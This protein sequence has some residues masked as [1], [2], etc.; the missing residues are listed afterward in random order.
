MKRYLLFL[1]LFIHHT[2][3]QARENQIEII[4]S[5]STNL[6]Q[7]E[8]VTLSVSNAPSGATFQWVKDGADLSSAVSSSLLVNTAGKY[9]VRVNG[10]ALTEVTVVVNPRPKADFT[11]TPAGGCGK[12]RINFSSTSTNGGTPPTNADLQYQWDFGDGKSS[13][14]QNPAHTFDPGRGTGTTVF[15]VRLIV[16]NS[17]G[18]KDTITRALSIGKSPDPTLLSSSQFQVINGEPYFKICAATGQRFEFLNGSGTSATNTQYIIR[19]GDGTPDFV[20]N[21]F[22]SFITHDYPVGLK[23]LTFIVYSGTCVDSTVYNIFVGNIPAGG[24]TGLGGSTICAGDA[25]RFVISGTANNPPGTIYV[26]NY[27]DGTRNDTFFHPAPD[28]VIHIYPKSSCGTSSSTG[29]TNF[30]N[31]FG[32]Y[33]TITNPCGTASGSIVPI[34]V[35]DK[36]KADFSISRDSICENQ[37]VTFTNTGI[38]GNNVQG[39][40]CTPGKIV[41]R[42]SS[43]TPGASWTVTSGTLGNT[44]GSLNPNFWNPAGTNALTV[45]FNTQGIYSITQITANN[46]LCGADSVTKTICVNPLPTAAFTLDKDNG[47]A[48]LNVTAAGTTNVPFCGNN[49][50][51]WTVSYTPT[52]GCT[53]AAS[54]F[55]YTGGTNQNSQNPQFLFSNPGVY[56]I[57]LQTFAP[58]NSCSSAVVQQQVVVR[59]KPV[60]SLNVPAE[61]CEGASISPTAT[62]TCYTASATYSWLFGGANP[63]SASQLNPGSI[64]YTAPGNYNIQFSATNECG[65]TTL[66]R[67]VVIKPTPQVNL[68]GN[69]VVCAG[70]TVGP[71]NFTT[72]PPGASLSWS[73][74]N[75]AIGLAASGMGNINAFTA[76]NN[77]SNPLIATISVTPT[78]NGCSGPA[79]TMTITVNPRPVVTVNSAA[80]CLGS[81]VQLNAGGADTYSWSPATGLSAVT[82]SSVTASPSTTTVYTVT[83]TNMA[84]G[85]F[86]SATATVTVNPVPSIAATFSNP[87]TCGSATGSITITG[88]TSNISYTVNYLR[89]GL[90]QP[91]LVRTATS[92]GIIVISGLTAATYSDIRVLLNGCASNAVG[93]FSLSDP[94]PPTVT[95]PSS[96]LIVCAGGATGLITFSANPSG[97]TVNWTNNNTSI[98]LAASG[99]SNIASFIASNNTTSPVTAT[100]TVTAT[101]AGCTS[102]AQTFRIVVNPRPQVSVNSPTICSG[103]SATLTVNGAAD[104][105]VWSPAA[106][107]N[108]TSGNTVVANP[109]TT[110]LYTIVASFTATGCSSTISSNVTVRPT[111]AIT[112]TTANPAACGASNGSITIAGLNP[113]TSYTVNYTRNGVAQ[114][115]VTRSSN[116]SG[117]LTLTN[118][119]AGT[120]SDIQ[121]TLNGCVSNTAG[122]F[123]LTDPS[124]PDQPI[125]PSVAPVC[126]GGTITL[127]ISNP[128]SGATYIWTGPNG[129]NQT[130]TATSVTISNASVAASGTY[131]AV[132]RLSNCNSSPGSVDVIVNPRPAVNVNSGFVCIGNSI[133]LTASGA[134]TYVWTPATGL[135]T[136]TGETVIASPTTNTNYTVTGTITATGCSNSAVSTVTVRTTPVISGDFMQ[137]TSC[138]ASN[139]SITIRQLTAGLNYSFTYTRNGIS[140]SGT[141][142]ASG[143]GTIVIANLPAGLYADIRVVLNGCTSNAI[144][145]FQL[146]EPSAPA[147][148]VVTSNSPL[149]SGNTL[150]IAVGNPV[151]G[152]TY[153]WAGPNGFSQTTTLPEVSIPNAQ[154]NRSGSYTVVMTTNNCPS[155]PASVSITVNPTPP[156]PIVSSPV[157]YCQGEPALP[158][159]AIAENGNTLLWYS[160]SSGG[161]GSSTAPTPSTNNTGSNSFFVSQITPEGCEGPRARIDVTVNATPV[162]VN[163]Q[164]TI[165]SGGAISFVPPGTPAGTVF[166]W[167]TP[168]LTAGLSGGAGGSGSSITGVFTN[169]TD[170]PQ[171]ATYNVSTI[172]GNCPGNDFQLIVTVNP[173]PF[174]PDL[175]TEI[176][177]GDI[178][179]ITPG[180]TIPNI[181][182]PAGTTYSWLTPVVT[183]AGAVS[184]ISAQSMGQTSISQQL[185][186]TTN[187]PA[188]VTYTVTPMSTSAGSC[189]GQPFTVVVKVNPRPSIPNQ[190]V[191]ICSG[192][193][194]RVSPQNNPPGSIVPAN[195]MYIWSAP[196]SNPAGAITGGTAQNIPQPF[197]GQTLVNTTVSPATISYTVTPISGDEGNCTGQPFEVVVTVNPQPA[198]SDI[199]TTICSNNFF[200]V[201]PANVPAN[202]T[203]TW[204]MPVSNP[205]GAITGG[206]AQAIPQ[207]AVSQRLISNINVPATLTYTVTPS[208]GSCGNS[209][210]NVVVTVNPAPK[211]PAQQL[212][213]C[214]GQTFDLRF[215][216]NPP[217][218]I[219]PVNTT[220]TWPLPL[221]NPAGIVSGGAIQTT[222]V[223]GIR[224]T[225]FN[226]SDA[227]ATLNYVITPVSGVPGNCPGEPF[228]LLAT[229]H[230]DA[231][232]RFTVLFDTAC[233]PFSIDKQVLINTSPVTATETFEWYANNVLIGTGRDFPGYVLSA[234]GDSVVIKMIARSKFGCKP[235]SVQK[236]FFTKLKPDASFVNANKGGCGPLSVNF[237]NTS[238]F[239][240]SFRYAWNFGNG[241]TSSLYQPGPIVFLPNPNFGDTSYLVTLLAFNE[242]DT[243]RFTTTINVQSGPQARFTPDKTVG[244]SPMTVTFNNTSRGINNTY[245]WNFGDGTVLTASDATPVSHTYFSGVRDTFVVRLIAVN[246]CGSDTAEFNVVITPNTIK[247]D[248]AV[249]GLEQNG[250]APHTVRFINNSSGASV[251][252]WDFGDGNILSTTKNKDT[253]VH[254]FIRLGSYRVKLTASNACSDTTTTEL[255]EVFN[256]PV[257]DFTPNVF[258]A[259][260]GDALKFENQSSGDATSYLWK[261]GDGNTSSLVS[262]THQYRLPGTYTVTL[263]AFKN[264]AP[265]SVCSDSIKRV[266]NIVDSLPI[267]FSVSANLGTCTPFKVRFTNNFLGYASLVWD[268]GDGNKGTGDNIEHTYMR[269]G[270]YF[271][272]LTITTPAGC[273]YTGVKRIEVVSPE[274]SLRVQTGVN[275]L[276][277]AV[278]FEALPVNAD[279]IIW[280][281]GDGTILKTTT[282]VVFHQ[283]R[284]PGTYYPTAQFKSND[285]CIYQVPDINEVKIDRIVSG[286][287]V[288]QQQECGKTIVRFTDTSN[289]FFGKNAVSWK[290]GDGAT[291]TGNVVTHTYTLSKPYLVQQI[292]TG[293]SGCADTLEMPVDVFVR[294]VPDAQ[295]QIPNLVCTNTPVDFRAL[296]QS[297]DPIVVN[298]WRFSNGIT[299]DKQDL[300]LTFATPGNYDVR[301]IAGTRFGCFDTAS[302]SFRVY[303]SPLVRAVPDVTICRGSSVSLS[304]S[305]AAQYTWY[306]DNGLTCV[307]C[308][309]TTA[310]P[311]VTTPYTVKGT[312]TDGCIAYDTVLVRVVQPFKM[313]VEPG[314]SICIGQS[315]QLLA[316]G[317]S[318][319]QWTPATGLNSTTVSNP[320]ATPQ[321]TTRYRVVGFDEFNCFTDTGF[322]MVGVGPYPTVSL[323]P[324]LTLATG[325]QHKLV[326]TITNGPIARWMWTPTTNLN[327]STCP[328]PIATIKR[329]I[330]YAVKVTNH[331]GCS[332]SDTL[333]IKVFCESS[334]VYIPNAFS[335]DGDGH[336][337]IFMVRASGIMQIKS[338]RIFSRW[339]EIV[340][341]KTNILPN[342]PSSGWDGRVR[343]VVMGPDVYAY[344]VEVVCDNGT[345]Y[346]LKGN[347]TLLR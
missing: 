156:A 136:T 199:S 190:S 294:S 281:F 335:P 43:T 345:P 26:L 336:N 284:N 341:E 65:T 237:N 82:G 181:I 12:T 106:G 130:T 210:F 67:P 220:F 32:T 40:N 132:T 303:P 101:L 314:D 134:D 61:A 242:C 223:S 55:V 205:A 64:S 41:W 299:S 208:A 225:L 23:K 7:G 75:M 265:G 140:Q 99:A 340:F 271:V 233:Y 89:N 92:G 317:A 183:P 72:A 141:A 157:I 260:I 328:E 105:Y 310:T 121:V 213:I 338:V 202:T 146:N 88:L 63:S 131:S 222:G 133:T 288:E 56:T 158:L 304:A 258:S 269:S 322:V 215:S 247:L 283:Y 3:I 111:P 19:W 259:C 209:S 127:S 193:S 165:C 110:T 316:S 117:I 174:I 296:V 49:R 343:G 278:R 135:N 342:D 264:N 70:Q 185:T 206:S 312:S 308:A 107:L 162:F 57:R 211:I 66:S 154:V 147:A 175:S 287:R 309:A 119:F 14:S 186:N 118:L 108:A 76:V 301:F 275:C 37:T 302:A 321:F 97:A 10:T 249:N 251:F 306:P 218:L 178:F 113:S 262:P 31:A 212:D 204:T 248:V 142:T 313:N 144:G 126:A 267:D 344:T 129:F 201:I 198:V 44:N 240:P 36:P 333:N 272:R 246:A 116:A 163:Q 219:L 279:T 261:F 5:G 169:T 319:Y 91:P 189:G 123:T 173:R 103:Q 268:F 320:V 292:V 8:T 47:C 161:T 195:T 323:G 273:V 197:I 48:P 311:L 346:F 77:T 172:L 307:Q 30:S 52:P 276:D 93:P 155:Q 318:T 179:T 122:P 297:A 125:I 79:R 54:G 46:T 200:N 84:T 22:N 124:A 28:T 13:T 326:S 164:V 60:V 80:I 227:S 176:C 286:F 239:H 229:V 74:N 11:F 170:Q 1:L 194:F 20:S 232:A 270:L 139:G 289:V 53:P 137:P 45:R 95:V 196:V 17:S 115:P 266:I 69:I 138:G 324:D 184:G 51:S 143:A 38:A 104:S 231:K 337:D 339:G 171:T 226:S 243:A 81:S 334:Q 347:L 150:R 257:A 277:A 102:G 214:T 160:S 153:T 230:P 85:C 329:E 24:I 255:I 244:C 120:Y 145:P 9:N 29:Q 187:R 221:S 90:S 166:I 280:N 86:N 253:V 73:N 228:S 327:C 109:A 112:V 114:G 224:Q 151:A 332:A 234:P 50:F 167:T 325:T 159:T 182:L 100:I 331:F 58:G 291:A 42:I 290:L 263:I 98:G 83:G 68:P 27:N 238:T 245:I 15:N 285:G 21:T 87:S 274:G 293:V 216:H 203:Y 62:A 256:K 252:R 4:A 217:D 330:S 300:Q 250:C 254:A 191:T 235:D 241:Q 96:D 33:L 18:C 78:L 25:Q 177:S 2:Y 6:C 16:T 152:A 305:G 39:G 168:I 192:S 59:E 128:V 315:M 71:V 282:R 149:C 148:P 94:N 298:S 236:K 295:L 188:T 34:Y 207:S 180:T 35:S